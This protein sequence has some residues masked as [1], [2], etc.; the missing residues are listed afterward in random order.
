LLPALAA[1]LPPSAWPAPRQDRWALA[2]V[3]I[4][5]VFTTGY[6]AIGIG[7]SVNGH[8]DSVKRFVL[9]ARALAEREGF[10]IEVVEP[11]DEGVLLY[12]ER[13]TYL[14]H[15]TFLAKW[16]NREVDAAIVDLNSLAEIEKQLAPLDVVLESEATDVARSRYRLVRRGAEPET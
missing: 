13:L 2:L 12:A 7:R 10:S 11:G 8:Y 3:S 16:E 4:A 9:R 5:M 1:R 15:D 6:T 14:D